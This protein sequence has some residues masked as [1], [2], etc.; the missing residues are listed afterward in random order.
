MAQVNGCRVHRLVRAI[1]VAKSFVF[2]V[3]L[4]RLGERRF[5]RM[6]TLASGMINT[7]MKALSY[8]GVDEINWR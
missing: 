7:N 6:L 1:I 5:H 8:L 2:D 3:G 4:C